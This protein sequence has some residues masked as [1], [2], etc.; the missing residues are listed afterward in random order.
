MKIAIATC[1]EKSELSVG[2]RALAIELANLG[3]QVSPL[4]WTNPAS[5]QQS[6]DAILIRSVWDYHL[7]SQAFLKWIEQADRSAKKLFNSLQIINWNL[8]KSY[9]LELSRNGI[10]C[11]PSLFI[12]KGTAIARVL[13]LIRRE[14]WDEIVVKPT[15]S[16]TSYL[17]FKS[18]LL[19][20]ELSKKIEKIQQHSEVLIQAYF[21]SIETDGEISLIFINGKAQEY[22]HAILKAPRQGDFRVQSDFGGA[23]VSYHATEALIKFADLALRRIA[24]DWTFA[25]VDVID[26]RTRPLVAEIELIEPDLFLQLEATAAR[27]L[28]LAIFDKLTS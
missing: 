12:N 20:Q 14:N 19:D 1:A 15:I 24:G 17:T 13:E 22:S 21:K 16:A 27:K 2:D 28:A 23:A 7:H 25:R 5:L 9:L 18:S 6:W 26:W 8:D 3:A 10:D 11:V 4:I